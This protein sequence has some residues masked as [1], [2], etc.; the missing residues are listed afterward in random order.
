MPE[1]SPA[2]LR[3]ADLKRT[4]NQPDPPAPRPRKMAYRF[5]GTLVIVSRDC[6]LGE[7]RKRSH[8]QHEG[9]AA[10]FNRLP[11]LWTKIAA[12]L[13]EQDAIY[14]LREQQL[15]RALFFRQAVVAVAEQEVIALLQCRV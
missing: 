6:V 9:N 1:S 15:D 12:S 3:V 7:L 5:V 4:A 13:R 2:F 8:H 14:S 11:Q 10:I